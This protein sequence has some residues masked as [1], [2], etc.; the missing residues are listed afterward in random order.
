MILINVLLVLIVPL[1]QVMVNVMVR[2]NVESKIVKF[3]VLEEITN[4]VNFVMINM[5]YL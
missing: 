4:T 1:S 5:F 2:P 3:V